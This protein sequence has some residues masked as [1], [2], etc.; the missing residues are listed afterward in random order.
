VF[1]R[2]GKMEVPGYSGRQ[3]DDLCHRLAAE[4]DAGGS[5]RPLIEK[6]AFRRRKYSPRYDIDAVDWFL[7]RFLLPPGHFER[8]GIADDP[9]GDLPVAELAPGGVSGLAEIYAHGRPSP[10]RSRMYFA[11]Q[12]E[13]AWR[14]FGQVPGTRLW[15]GKAPKG[16]TELRIAE[17]QTLVSMQGLWKETV[18]AGGRIFTWQRPFATDSSSPFA[19]ELL[20]R[21]D[22]DALGHYAENTRIRTILTDLGIGLTNNASVRGLVDG[23]GTPILY[24]AGSNYNWRACACILFPDQRWLRFLVRGSGDKNAIMTAV[25]QAANKVARYRLIDKSVRQ[26]GYWSWGSVEIMV[27]PGWKLTDELTLA[28]ALSPY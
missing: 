21:A 5:A 16:L 4:L 12:C 2:A 9:W 18:S 17:Q 3:V 23:T 14:D 19:A 15:W 20:A 24:T 28:L 27:H 1:F 10:E 7:D 13:S 11:E 8:G 22:R 26:E 25:D 6:A